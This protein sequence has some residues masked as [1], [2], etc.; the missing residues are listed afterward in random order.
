[1]PAASS[2][3]AALA[4][5]ILSEAYERLQPETAHLQ[6]DEADAL[7]GRDLRRVQGPTRGTQVPHLAVSHCCSQSSLR[8]GIDTLV[9]RYGEVRFSAFE[10][11]LTLLRE[12]SGGTADGTADCFIDIGS[13][14]GK[15][16]LFAAA[17]GLQSVGIELVHSRH[18][19]G[20]R[21]QQALLEEDHGD[22]KTAPLA[23]AI[24]GRIGGASLR[25]ADALA[26]SEAD[27]L[28]NG[29]LFLCNNAVWPSRLTAEVVTRGLTPERAPRLS[30]L[31]TLKEVPE[32][33]LEAASLVLA[34]ASCVSVTWDPIGWPLFVYCRRCLVQSHDSS[35]RLP[36]IDE[37]FH[38][39]IESRD[40]IAMYG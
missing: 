6:P 7:T 24:Q 34:R 10:P 40:G 25:C 19:V 37:S 18:V 39:G 36:V 12:H 26:P 16:V 13:G 35:Q 17:L 31:A 28:A 8:P 27:S 30:V 15:L 23:A 1:M 38:I 4:L 22:E 11:L 3:A 33:A 20:L 21:V 5:D 29:T 32:E 2:S 9:H 14:T